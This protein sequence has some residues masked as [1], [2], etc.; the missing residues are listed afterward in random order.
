MV[1]KQFQ[2]KPPLARHRLVHNALGA[3][4]ESIHALSIKSA[5]TPEQAAA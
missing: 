5:K 3:L 2:C 1:S 4:M